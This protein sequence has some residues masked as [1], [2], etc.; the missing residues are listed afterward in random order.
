MASPLQALLGVASTK[1]LA[2]E[3]QLHCTPVKSSERVVVEPTRLT[4]KHSSVRFEQI[5][6]TEVAP[7]PEPGLKVIPPHAFSNFGAHLRRLCV[8]HTV[9]FEHTQCAVSIVVVEFRIEEWLEKQGP[10][11]DV[12]YL[13]NRVPYAPFDERF[14]HWRWHEE[15]LANYPDLGRRGGRI[16]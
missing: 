6:K 3:C 16:D 2:S 7:V 13:R 11:V 14:A 9:R 8:R 1:R 10:D 5:Q 12:T 4:G 15:D